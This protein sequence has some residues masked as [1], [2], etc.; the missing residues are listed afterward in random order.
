MTIYSVK[1]ILKESLPI[2]LFLL[3]LS[4]ITGGILE[5]I[6]YALIEEHIYLF[7]TLPIFLTSVGDIGCVFVSR[8]TSHLHLG[9]LSPSFKPYRVLFSNIFGITLTSI[10][11]FI[12]LSFLGYAVA[13]ISGATISIFQLLTVFLVAGLLT[14][15]VLYVVGIIVTMFTFKKGWDPDNFT[16]PLIANAGDMIGAITLALLITIFLI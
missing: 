10:G 15:C 4:W 2:S 16:S 14:T 1:R 7:V 3:T 6:S 8:L 9:E 5:D 11:Y 13:L 12:L